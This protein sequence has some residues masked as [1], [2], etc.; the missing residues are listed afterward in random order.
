VMVS[1]MR[2]RG[3]H[4]PRRVDIVQQRI[5]ACPSMTCQRGRPQPREPGILE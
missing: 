4:P 1:L 3:L 2:C 5:M